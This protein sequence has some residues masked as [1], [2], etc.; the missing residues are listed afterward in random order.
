[1][2]CALVYS[3]I[4]LPFI[5]KQNFCHTSQLTAHKVSVVSQELSNCETLETLLVRYAKHI[6]LYL[7]SFKENIEGLKTKF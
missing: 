1:M 7:L 2:L 4:S 6:N 5:N 3:I